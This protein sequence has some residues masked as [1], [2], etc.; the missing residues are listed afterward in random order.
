MPRES[1]TS[2]RQRLWDWMGTHNS[3][4]GHLVLIQLEVLDGISRPRVVLEAQHYELLGEAL[5]SDFSREWWGRGSQAARLCLLPKLLTC[6]LDPLLHNLLN[7]LDARNLWSLVGGVRVLG[8]LV[9]TREVRS[10]APSIALSVGCLRGESGN[11]G[12]LD[13]SAPSFLMDWDLWRISIWVASWFW[14]RTIASL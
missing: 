2:C 11:G 10:G 7:V 8:M 4:G 1:R 3:R 12:A 5:R 13:P 6:F 9:V 14:T